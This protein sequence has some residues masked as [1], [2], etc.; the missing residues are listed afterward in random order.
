MESGLGCRCSRKSV[1]QPCPADGDMTAAEGNR[2]FAGGLLAG[3]SDQGERHNSQLEAPRH[4][5]HWLEAGCIL[6]SRH[7]TF[8][9]TPATSWFCVGV[10]SA[11]LSVL[12][13]SGKGKVASLR[14]ANCQ[15]LNTTTQTTAAKNRGSP[16]LYSVYILLI[17]SLILWHPKFISILPLVLTTTYR[18]LR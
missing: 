7:G 12:C 4:P 2:W 3:G 1:R 13:V 10:H 16:T 6:I 5:G 15:P 17:R 9:R 14:G 8:F 18:L 11:G